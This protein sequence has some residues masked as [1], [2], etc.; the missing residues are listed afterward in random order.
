MINTLEPLELYE[1][2]IYRFSATCKAFSPDL[3]GRVRKVETFNAGLKPLSY[4]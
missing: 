1:P 2:F 4:F 3:T